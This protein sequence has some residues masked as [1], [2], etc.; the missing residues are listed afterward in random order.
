VLYRLS[1]S[2]DTLFETISNTSTVPNSQFESELC[3]CVTA[4]L[5]LPVHSVVPE[6][7]VAA[8]HGTDGVVGHMLY[9][10]RHSGIH[11]DGTEQYSYVVCQHSG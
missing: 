7:G 5:N 4:A 6:H 8:M 11:V 2:G 10:Q 9:G 3:V 1:T